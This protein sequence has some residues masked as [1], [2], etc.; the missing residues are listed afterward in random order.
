MSAYFDSLNRRARVAV[1]RPVP[2]A[3]E[4]APAPAAQPARRAT[5]PEMAAGY[6]TLREKLLVAGKGGRLKT[7]LFAGCEGGEG[8]TRVVREFADALA[9]SGL[10]VLLVDADFRT[11]G[12]TTSTATQGADLITL[13]TSGHPLPAVDWGKGKLTVVPSPIGHPEKERFLNDPAMVDWLA[14]QRERYDYVLLDA[15]PV[16]GAADGTLLGRLCDG[17]VV[18][19]RAARTRR[20]AIERARRQLADAG[21]VVLGAILNRAKSTIP[22]FLEPYFG[23]E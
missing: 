21:V 11:A 23:H 4:P 2:A 18:V 16:L 10:N 6:R 22:R 9:S 5:A 15:P 17:V 3:P 13:V 8:C 19:V 14:T 7:I 20:D 1:I 12:L